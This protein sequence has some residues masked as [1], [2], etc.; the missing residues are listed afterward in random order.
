MSRKR[1]FEEFLEKARKIHGDKYD[2]SK[3][4]YVDAHTKVC[5]ICPIHG[6]FWQIPSSHLCGRGCP[7]CANIKRGETF[8]ISN[9]EYFNLAILKHNNKYKY[10]GVYKGAHLNITGICPYH[11]EFEVMACKHL[12]G[13]GCPV[14]AQESRNKSKHSKNT[15]DLINE[16]KTKYGDR[17]D[18]SEIVYINAH[19]PV[20]ITDKELN[21]RYQIQPT[22]L[23]T[24]GPLQKI[25]YTLEL[26]INKAREIHGDKYDYSKVAFK[27]MDTP[28]CIICPIHG[29]FWQKPSDHLLGYGCKICG[30]KRS[31]DTNRKTKEEFVEEGNIVHGGVYT[32]DDFEYINFHTPGDITCPIHGNFKQTPAK[33]LS[34]HG[35]PLCNESSLE[36]M[37][38][39]Y[40]DNNG[41]EYSRWFTDDW[42]KN[43]RGKQ[44]FDFILPGN[45][46]IECQGIQHFVKANFK[47]S[48]DVKKN[49]ER[50]ERKYKLAIER[51]YKVFYFTTEDNA[52]YSYV[53]HIYDNG[54]YTDIDDLFNNI[55]KDL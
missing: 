2:Y 54:I 33:H 42:L 51:G 10:K 19:T 24:R 4:E 16:I 3:V 30:Y 34:G 52:K 15:Q 22:K 44:S 49:I 11:G 55:K 50:D 28:V 12:Q 14:C 35:C 25:K 23:L 21:Y 43:G 45:I 32:Y 39:V 38:R 53:S 7:K 48:V 13:V 47:Y 6:E 9:E 41:I 31:S 37:L 36:R 8:K 1:T 40:M 27:G 26:F 29:E 17:L 5:I 18:C 20:W 46:L